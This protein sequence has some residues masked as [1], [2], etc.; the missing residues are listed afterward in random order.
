MA[1]TVL[2][3]DDSPL[4]RQMLGF[5]LMAAGMTVVE[6]GSGVE[7]LARLAEGEVDIALV[8]LNMPQ[9]DGYTF[10]SELRSDPRYE[11]LP[12]VIITTEAEAA[13]RER[14]LA[15]GADVYLTKPVEEGTLL[16]T[17]QMLVGEG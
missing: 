2:I 15:A 6:A 16:A 9:M 11:T 14:G 7:G 10:I 3:V 13:D 1:T 4:V 17:V 8:D 5:T 12:V